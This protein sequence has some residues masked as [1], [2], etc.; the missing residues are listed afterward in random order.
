MDSAGSANSCGNDGCAEPITARS[1]D[2][3]M[4]SDAGRALRASL[5]AATVAVAL[6][7]SIGGAA[8]APTPSGGLRQPAGAVGCITETGSGGA[9]ADGHDLLGVSDLVASADGRY[10]YAAAPGSDAVVVFARDAGTGALTEISCV[11][12]TGSDGRCLDGRKLESVRRLAI[13]PDGLHVYAASSVPASGED[14]EDAVAVLVRDPTSGRLSPVS[15]AAGCVSEG[16]ADDGCTQAVP[17]KDP[18]GLVVSPDGR[19]VYVVSLDSKP[20]PAGD[21]HGVAALARDPRSGALSYVGYVDLCGTVKAV[22]AY[23]GNLVD[24]GI[25]ADGRHVYAATRIAVYPLSRQTGSGALALVPGSLAGYHLYGL[26]SVAVSPD[27]RTV[28]AAAYDF[29]HGGVNVAARNPETGALALLPGTDGCVGFGK[30]LYLPTCV[31]AGPA[32]E[33]AWT[34]AV[35]PDGKFVYGGGAGIS[36]FARDARGALA[37]IAGESGCAVPAG[38]AIQGCTAT[39]GVSSLGRM[40]VAPDGRHLYAAASDG[41]AVFERLSAGAPTCREEAPIQARSGEPVTVPLRCSD[42]NGDPLTYS[43]VDGPVRGRLG[44]IDQAAASVVYTSPAGFQGKDVFSY[45]ASDGTESAAAVTVVLEI[46]ARTVVATILDR[47]AV[48]GPRG[49]ARLRLAGRKDT[50]VRGVLVLRA[51]RGGRVLGHAAF[52]LPAGRTRTVAVRLSP[53]ALEELRRARVLRAIAVLTVRGAGGGAPRSVR[54]PVTL[55][56]R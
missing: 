10:L 11:S 35:S 43:I 20:S 5:E 18:S 46:T 32:L 40:L 49:I 29:D 23:C 33:G 36:G 50:D 16:G 4:V 15:G 51:R 6:L 45:T 30:D 9:C 38:S 7:A 53:S 26:G 56:A 27:G 34:V 55:Q 1:L 28:Y 24:V 41:V 37:R 54:V 21:Q 12:E 47:R 25:S 48:V 13:S 42:P 14:F 17:I 22:D 44:A 3:I 19:N 39:R 31:D 8:A 2:A 52:T